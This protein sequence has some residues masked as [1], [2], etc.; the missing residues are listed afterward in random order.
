MSH[1]PAQPEVAIAILYERLGHI[2]E[3]IE[4][5]D[6]KLDTQNRARAETLDDLERRVQHVEKSLDRARWFLA[7]IAAGGGALGGGIAAL[8][9]RA[10]GA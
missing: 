7:G 10:I 1:V 4:H 2:A 9:A 8:I 6:R 3:R 5:L